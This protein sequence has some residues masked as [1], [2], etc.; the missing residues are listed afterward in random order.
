MQKLIL[1]FFYYKTN[2]IY[3]QKNIKIKKLLK[4]KF[5]INTTFIKF[6][7]NKWVNN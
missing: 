7:K 6:E 1:S 4:L 3:I 2:N 5:L